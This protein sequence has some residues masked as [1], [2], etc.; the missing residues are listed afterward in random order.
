MV[1]KKDYQKAGVESWVC[2]DCGKLIKS[3]NPAQQAFNVGVHIRVCKK[4]AEKLVEETP[5][6][7]I[8]RKGEQK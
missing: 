5:A 3:L 8:H 2:P 4:S 6:G 1:T 7:N